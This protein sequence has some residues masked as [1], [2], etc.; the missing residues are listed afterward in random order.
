MRAFAF[1]SLVALLSVGAFG[2][3]AGAPDFELADVHA[4][5]RGTSQY[6]RGGFLRGD[7]YELRTAT[8]LSLIHEAYGVDYDK[9]LGG[10]GWL[11]T[12]ST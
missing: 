3:T 6:T 5:A 7:R 12:D 1:S 10:P 2:Q 11:E 8:M 9:I 4:S